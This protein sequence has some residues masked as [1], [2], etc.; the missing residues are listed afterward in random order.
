MKFKNRRKEVEVHRQ[1]DSS[2]R[3]N[4]TAFPQ[5]QRFLGKDIL[6]F[7]RKL[8]QE[9]SDLK[10]SW[11]FKLFRHGK[12]R[13]CCLSVHFLKQTPDIKQKFRS[14]VFFCKVLWESLDLIF[15]GNL[16]IIPLWQK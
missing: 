9:S 12:I 15:P 4:T 11:K 13:S 7:F 1:V 10:L 14:Q 6:F 2:S 8:L 5:L 3:W 16:E